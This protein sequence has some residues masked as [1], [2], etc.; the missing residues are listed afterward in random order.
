MQS[1]LFKQLHCN[2][3]ISASNLMYTT[4]TISPTKVFQ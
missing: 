1:D 2:E 4:Y 3:P